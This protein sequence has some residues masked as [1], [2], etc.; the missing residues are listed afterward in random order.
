MID[1]VFLD[2]GRE[3]Q[4]KPDPNFP[5]GRHIVMA[6]KGVEVCTW[7]L[8]Y[9][10][11]RCGFYNVECKKCGKKATISVAGRIDDPRILTVACKRR[12]N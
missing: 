4:C 6:E 9:P 3:P 10:A 12:P 1:V 2:S 8:P 5:D 11:P 7:N